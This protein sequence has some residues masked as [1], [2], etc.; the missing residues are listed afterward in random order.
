MTVTLNSEGKTI[1]YLH[2][3]PTNQQTKK[4][5]KIYS[6]LIKELGVPPLPNIVFSEKTTRGLSRP[7]VQFGKTK[8]LP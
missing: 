1:I 6:S 7:H 5:I 2:T 4:R 8:Q 3:K